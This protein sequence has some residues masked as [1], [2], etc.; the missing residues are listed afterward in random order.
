[1]SDNNKFEQLLDLLV[2]EEK[3]KAEELFHDIV[4]EKS[5]EIY[6][7]LIES[8]A[9]ADEE[10]VEEASED[11]KEEAVD[12]ATDEKEEAV[13]ETTKEATDEE[14]DEDKV[15]ENFEISTFA[16]LILRSIAWMRTL[17]TF[18]VSSQL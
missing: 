7:G 3:E 5:K 2:N 10:A 17:W 9:P 12:E 16:D 11:K 14:K 13:E 8:E 4:V 6:Q 1:M 18:A 15:E